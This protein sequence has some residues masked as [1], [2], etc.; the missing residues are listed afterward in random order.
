MKIL[1]V[2]TGG[3]IGSGIV[4][5]VADVDGEISAQLP[6][7]CGCN[8]S[9]A[10]FECCMPLNMLSENATAQTISRI[11]SYMLS[12]DYQKYDGVIL[13]HGSDTLAYISAVLGMALSWVERPIVITAA[14]YVLQMSYSNG[15][16]NFR[17]CVDFIRGF[18]EGS[19]NNSGVFT[20]WQN[21]SENANV[22]IST[23]LNEADGY[24]DS[25]SSWGGVPFGY[26][27]DGCFV[28][29]DD[30][31]NPDKTEPNKRLVILKGKT[32][33]LNPNILLLHSYPNM[34]F[35]A[36]SLKNKEA[37]LL[38]MYHSA[39]VCTDG[40]C[41][42]FSLFA[43]RCS[44]SGI[45]IYV[46]SAKNAAY[47]YK[48]SHKVLDDVINLL[49]NINVYAAYMKLM[50]AYSREVNN[51]DILFDNLFYEVLPDR[52]SEFF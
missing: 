27:K 18:Y 22:Y 20:I 31:I 25:F 14:D 16:A 49:Y 33:S 41:T 35:S 51:T 3:T 32:I 48:S 36:V 40:D 5:G 29:N 6:K 28:K 13:T 15:R 38:V 42:S 9:N 7:L 19:H 4:D 39:T 11:V 26:I 30:R 52:L 43:E 23:R 21:K 2:L 50:L 45:P 10:E 46:C 12:V 44:K 17:F 37:V 1:V 47:S 24:C 34:D 8:N